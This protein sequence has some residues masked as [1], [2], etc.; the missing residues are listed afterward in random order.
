MFTML[1][2]FDPLVYTP[3]AVR[4]YGEPTRLS[5]ERALDDGNPISVRVL[6]AAET[7]G[8][9]RRGE[10]RCR[11]LIDRGVME[12]RER[13]FVSYTIERAGRPNLTGLVG[14]LDLEGAIIYPHEGVMPSAVAERWADI[15]RAGAFLEPV[16]VASDLS[17]VTLPSSRS[18]L[19]EVSYGDENH[20]VALLSPDVVDVADVIGE[21]GFVVLD[22]HHRIAATRQHAEHAGT[23]PLVLAMVVDH[24]SPGL[25]VEPQHRVLAGKIAS[26]DS[27]RGIAEVASYRRGEPV[28]SGSVAIVGRDVSVVLTI[29]A[30]GWAESEQRISSLTLERE[31]LGRLEMWVEGYATCEVDGYAELDAGAGAVAIMGELAIADIVDT[32]R[33]GVVLPEKTTCFTPKVAVG[34]VGALLDSHDPS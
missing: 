5:S 29:A 2:P 6:Q 7:P 28:V 20:V 26:V 34:L 15:E 13:G 3:D 22:G 18:V 9:Y 10:H 19:R 21:N 1:H 17:D 30:D 14:I 4:R 8:S 31:L 27:L 23:A 25:F 12:K 33:R 32:A 11:T 24:R 16:V